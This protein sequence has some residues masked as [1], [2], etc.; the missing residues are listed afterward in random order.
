MEANVPPA[1]DY[2]KPSHKIVESIAAFVNTHSLAGLHL[3]KFN[4]P[5]FVH[6]AQASKKNN[7]RHLLTLC[8]PAVNSVLSRRRQRQ[9]TAPS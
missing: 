5:R 1:P 2:V 8:R 6:V 7:T 4:I 9:L 3:A